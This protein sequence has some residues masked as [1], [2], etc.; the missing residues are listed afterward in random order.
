MS[1]ATL[2]AVI[3]YL[4]LIA[5][6]LPI[7]AQAA[8]SSLFALGMALGSVGLYF[9]VG[10]AYAPRVALLAAVS[11]VVA[12]ALVLAM[13]LTQIGVQALVP[14]P[15]RAVAAIWLTL[16]VA[17]DVYIGAGTV[18][19]GV[20]LWTVPG[21]RAWL[22][23]PGVLVGALLLALNLWTFPTPP[24]NAGLFDIGP[25]VALWYVAVAGRV[26]RWRVRKSRGS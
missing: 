23:G 3:A 5:V 4:A 15:G 13:L 2:A 16:D 14:E 19:F 6:D 12:T 20:A 7:P 11:N 22:G 25:V 8:L 10:P 21:F 1:S 17:W 26:A 9:L 18:L 24:A